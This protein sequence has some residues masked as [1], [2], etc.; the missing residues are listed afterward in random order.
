MFRTLTTRFMLG[1]FSMVLA[2]GSAMAID[3][4]HEVILLW[5]DGAPAAKGNAET[6]QPRMVWYPA[7]ADNAAGTCVIVCPG[8]GYAGLAWEKEGTKFAEFF[9][10]FG[11]SAFV[12]QY[13]VAPYK[14]PVPMHDGQR[15]I[16]L[17]RAQANERGYAPD[18]IGIMGFS[19][20][21]HLVTTLATHFDAGDAA[22]DDPIDRESCRPDFLIAAYPVITLTDPFTH[23][24]SRWNLLGKTP[25]PALV[26]LLSNEKQVTPETP[27]TF[28][29]HTANDAAVPSENS[30]QFYNA[31]RAAGVPAELH[32]F[33]DG[34]HGVGL[35]QDDPELK[36]WPS[37]LEAWMR[38][39]GLAK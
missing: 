30:T 35:A 22:S 27:P 19:A 4:D 38:S 13:R 28:L 24:G 5:P 11:V 15:A 8:G 33:E 36:V 32:I 21:G 26:E 7:P 34:A 16:R 14:H 3:T 9:N 25:D 29:F 39:R 23:Q 18:R 12:L 10:S 20:G 1:A 17:A 2:T 37:L 31:L 6:D